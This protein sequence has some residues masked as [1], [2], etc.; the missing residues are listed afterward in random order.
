MRTLQPVFFVFAF[1]LAVRTA[2]LNPTSFTFDSSGLRR[3]IPATDFERPSVP[4]PGPHRAVVPPSGA[5]LTQGSPLA[6]SAGDPELLSATLSATGSGTTH[7][8]DGSL[9]KVLSRR[10]IKGTP[11]EAPS[12]HS[13]S[14]GSAPA[15]FPDPDGAL[16]PSVPEPSP[17]S[18]IVPPSGAIPTQISP[19]ALSVGD[20]EFPYAIH[21]AMSSSATHYSDGSLGKVLSRRDIKG[22]PPEAPSR[23]SSSPESAPAHLPNP[24]GALGPSVPKPGPHSGVVPSSGAIPTRSSPQALSVGDPEFP[25]A[26]LS[27]TS[28]SATHYSNGS[29]G[30]VLSRRDIK[31]TPLEAPSQRSSSPGSAP[32]QFPDP[33]GALGSSVPEPSPHSAVVPPSGAIPTQVSLQALSVGDPEFPFATHSAMSSSVTHSDGSFGKGQ[34]H[35]DIEGAS[36]QRPVPP[37]SVPVRFLELGPDD[38][39]KDAI[40]TRNVLLNARGPDKGKGKE[41]PMILVELKFERLSH[42]SDIYYDVPPEPVQD[43]LSL[44]VFGSTK[45][46][47]SIG[48]PEGYPKD[49]K[50]FK[51]RIAGESDYSPDRYLYIAKLPSER[52]IFKYKA[53]LKSKLNTQSQAQEPTASQ[54]TVASSSDSTENFDF[55]IPDYPR[56]SEQLLFNRLTEFSWNNSSPSYGHTEPFSQS[57]LTETN[58]QQ[59]SENYSETPWFKSKAD[60]EK[61]DHH[62]GTYKE[63]YQE[64]GSKANSDDQT[65]AFHT[66]FDH[67]SLGQ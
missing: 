25:S 59:L 48:Y 42:H 36:P 54:P 29:L 8:S 1:A 18:A 62:S 17:H 49:T 32:A 21:S 47:D 46:K 43:Q 52:P 45:L 44:R 23:C 67:L 56:R 26:T 22:T 24:D 38:P 34:S 30:K 39:A 2:P 64:G 3:R 55:S 20:P 37:E 15:Q 14:P 50:R 53:L 12:Q 66:E 31:G 41:V 65:E 5:I 58:I 27:A 28:S 7:H 33:D 13:S 4:K 40:V 35:R 16:G 9:G 19:Q 61:S 6:L 63:P 11:L 57:G 51:Y 10:D 60:S